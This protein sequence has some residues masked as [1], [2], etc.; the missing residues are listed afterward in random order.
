MSD[1]NGLSGYSHINTLIG[2]ERFHV[3][4][5]LLSMI[6]LTVNLTAIISRLVL[7]PS[8]ISRKDRAL[9][10]G[11]PLAKPF[12]QSRGFLIDSHHHQSSILGLPPPFPPQPIVT[13]LP[14]SYPLYG[15]KKTT[16]LGARSIRHVFK[17]PPDSNQPVSSSFNPVI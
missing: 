7:L 8:T 2:Y 4:L 5:A 15:Y 14:S 1:R 3:L 10:L 13:K 17:C 12:L 9:V 16:K 6:P 11:W